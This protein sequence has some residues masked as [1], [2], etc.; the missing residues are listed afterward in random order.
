M[1]DSNI[2]SDRLY[3]CFP[4]KI[5]IFAFS[6]VNHH[7]EFEKANLCVWAVYCDSVGTARGLKA[8]VGKKKV[9][10]FICQW[11][12]HRERHEHKVSALIKH[13]RRQYQKQ[14]SF[15]FCTQ[16]YSNTIIITCHSPLFLETETGRKKNNNC[17]KMGKA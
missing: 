1:S 16:F 11:H 17:R 5:L 15:H 6:D 8:I 12:K 3:C 14:K 9:T 4:L 10:I 2:L 7:E 13:P